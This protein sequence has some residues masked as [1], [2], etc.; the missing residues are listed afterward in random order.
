M[1]TKNDI[2]DCSDPLE[3]SENGD[4][5]SVSGEELI[6]Q[7]IIRLLFTCPG[8][9]FHIPSLGADLQA[10]RNRTP[11]RTNLQRIENDVIRLLD[12]IPWLDDYKSK[13]YQEGNSAKLE[14]HARSGNKEI[15]IDGVHVIP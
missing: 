6:K 2:S 9:I 12:S 15:V 13:V 1:A 8:D 3:I 10:W 7:R 5:K 4:I 14:I 11:V